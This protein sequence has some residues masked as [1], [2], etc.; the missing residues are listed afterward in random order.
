MTSQYTQQDI[1]LRDAAPISIATQAAVVTNVEVF[2]LTENGSRAFVS[3]LG[4]GSDRAAP[5]VNNYTL[6]VL[7]FQVSRTA[8]VLTIEAVLNLNLAE[9]LGGTVTPVVVGDDV[10]LAIVGDAL[11]ANYDH[12][13][14][15]SKIFY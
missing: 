3:V 13:L 5:G 4:G 10:F 12:R 7:S 11:V 6:V 9:G 1:N 8:G 14:K 2:S 15:L